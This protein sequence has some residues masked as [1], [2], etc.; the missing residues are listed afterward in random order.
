M[1]PSKGGIVL[2]E[3]EVKAAQSRYMMINL[4][5]CFGSKDCYE[6][7][8]LWSRATESQRREISFADD[9]WVAM[10][11]EISILKAS[12]G[13]HAKL[14]RVSFYSEDNIDAMRVELEYLRAWPTQALC[15]CRDHTR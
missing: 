8:E 6:L 4:Y 10:A 7:D 14:P 1:G 3:E 15:H 9:P 5:D 11:V 12:L 2:T 13:E